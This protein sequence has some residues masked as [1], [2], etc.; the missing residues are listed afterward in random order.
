MKTLKTTAFGLVVGGVLL[1]TGIGL[2]Q[3]APAL[4][5]LPAGWT[6]GTTYANLNAWTI[7]PLGPVPGTNHP[8]WPLQPAAHQASLTP[9]P[10][11]D[12]QYCSDASGGAVFVPSGAPTD[13]LTCPA[14]TPAP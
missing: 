8:V 2:A 5:T 13:N 3:P 7:N 1:A 11:P 12:G 10:R 14:Q 6:P 9:S 4:A